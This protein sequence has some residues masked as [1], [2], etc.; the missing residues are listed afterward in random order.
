MAVLEKGW[1]YLL[2]PS[3]LLSFS[4]TTIG[5]LALGLFAVHVYRKSSGADAFG[6]LD[7][8]MI[9]AVILGLGLYFDAVYLLWVF[10]GAAGGWGS[11][12]AWILGHN[13]NLWMVS[14]PLLG[15]PMLFKRK[16]G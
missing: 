1:D 3:N 11:W 9:G 15:L 7:L 14:L 6:K 10:F 12:Y 4:L 2:Y 13:M 8:R 5:L 16:T